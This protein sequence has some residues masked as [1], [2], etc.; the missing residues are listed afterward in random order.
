MTFTKLF[1]LKEN[2][3]THFMPL[4][5][6]D[7]PW[8]YQMFSNVF[9]GYQKRPVGW[10]SLTNLLEV[11]LCV[12]RSLAMLTEMKNWRNRR[13]AHYNQK[14]VVSILLIYYLIF[15]KTSITNLR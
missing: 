15:F 1:S 13:L 7:T 10:N 8:K 12:I 3:L 2:V 14:H 5:S 11:W 4:V 9:N 6:F